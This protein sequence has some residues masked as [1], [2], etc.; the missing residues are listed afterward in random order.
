[1]VKSRDVV[2]VAPHYQN[3]ELVVV[4]PLSTTP[5]KKVQPYHYELPK[6][7]RPSGDALHAVWAKCDMLYTF[8]IQRLAMH[9]THNK[10]G[11][12]QS[13]RV[14]LPDEEFAAIKRCVAF[15]LNLPYN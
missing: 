11:V 15:A 10:H 1:M 9:T 14:R 8:S 5:P 6:D 3:R 2:V 12:R 13:V 7:P 4:V